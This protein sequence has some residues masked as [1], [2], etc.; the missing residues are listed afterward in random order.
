MILGVPRPLSDP[1]Q[2]QQELKVISEVNLEARERRRSGLKEESRL[3]P[4]RHKHSSRHPPQLETEQKKE[5]D[6]DKDNDDT[7]Q[8]SQTDDAGKEEETNHE[9]EETEE[10]EVEKNTDADLKEE[11]SGGKISRFFSNFKRK[12]NDGDKAQTNGFVHEE[13][14]KENES[15]MSE[16]NYDH[17]KEPSPEKGKKRVSFYR[18]KEKKEEDKKETKK[19]L[20]LKQ[21]RLRE[22]EEKRISL[23]E[24][25]IE[26]IPEEEEE[27]TEKDKEEENAMDSEENEDKEETESD[28]EE[29]SEL[30]TTSSPAYRNV[31]R[32]EQVKTKPVANFSGPKQ[33]KTNNKVK[34][35]SCVIL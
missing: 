21:E 8:E 34:S 9:Q 35:K 24:E 33:K 29:A 10:K 14:K 23:Q 3:P 20:P 25:Q 6:L 12:K 17:S 19:T 30:S 27:E 2:E 5:E 4:I 11:K 32:E 16:D 26:D 7:Y 31:H 1:S 22:E 13:R 28:T 15:D 18:Q